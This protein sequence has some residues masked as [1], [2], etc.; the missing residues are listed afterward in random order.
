MPHNSSSKLLRSRTLTLKTVLKPHV[1][2]PNQHC[3]STRSPDDAYEIVTSLR[4][5]ISGFGVAFVSGEDNFVTRRSSVLLGMLAGG[6]IP[7]QNRDAAVL[8]DCQYGTVGRES[9]TP[10]LQP[11]TIPQ[12]Q[13]L[14]RYRC[15]HVQACSSPKDQDFRRRSR[16]CPLGMGQ[17]SCR[18][19]PTEGHNC[20]L[21]RRSCQLSS[22]SVMVGLDALLNLACHAHKL[23]AIPGVMPG[24]IDVFVRGQE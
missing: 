22:R 17:Q 6:R 14:Y 10:V 12:L 1:T 23:Q 2:L 15:V 24:L 8:G 5:V 16:Q 21:I 20:F 4:V 7:R 11:S 18:Y 9:R 3:S 19:I 13:P